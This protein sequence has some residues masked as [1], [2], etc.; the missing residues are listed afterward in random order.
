MTVSAPNAPCRQTQTSVA[1]GHHKDRTSCSWLTG[2]T[3]WRR[4]YPAYFNRR[5]PSVKI[6][7][8]ILLMTPVFAFATFRLH[9]D[10]RFAVWSVMH[11]HDLARVAQADAIITTW[12]SWGMAGSSNDSYLVSDV[13]DD[14]RTVASA[15]QWRK[16]EESNPLR[17]AAEPADIAR[18]A[19]FLASNLACYVN[20][21]V[22]V[23]D[24]GASN[25]TSIPRL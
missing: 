19:L 25:A 24:G 21:N 1:A 3:R 22:L 13:S 12:D 16:I 8:L 4:R 20:G 9:D 7:S 2:E 10:I 23:L 18:A 17:R 14:S 11:A 6:A 15:E 5:S